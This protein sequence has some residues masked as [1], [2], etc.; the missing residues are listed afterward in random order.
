MGTTTQTQG[1]GR[2]PP[3][4]KLGITCEWAH[5]RKEQHRDNKN[6]T[7]IDDINPNTP[8]QGPTLLSFAQE[9]R[10]ERTKQAKLI[11]GR[12]SWMAR[13]ASGAQ[14][15][16]LS[17]F[18]GA[19]R[20]VDPLPHSKQAWRRGGWPRPL[21][22][23]SPPKEELVKLE[24]SRASPAARALPSPSTPGLSPR[25]RSSSSG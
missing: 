19:R 16:S 20:Q 9:K 5:N 7:M 17:R 15:D 24:E 12:P 21:L 1:L 4:P 8:P 18:T 3:R 22:E 2:S 25:P 23:E 11:L 13:A 14:A 10:K 6:S